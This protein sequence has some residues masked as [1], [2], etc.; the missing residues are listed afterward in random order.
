MMS[1]GASSATPVRE[2]PGTARDGMEARARAGLAA[3]AAAA[4]EAAFTAAADRLEP[5][6]VPWEMHEGHGR[7]TDKSIQP[8]SAP[9]PAMDMSELISRPA[10]HEC[11]LGSDR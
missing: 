5:A 8:A 9:A 3:A 7:A 6:V 11:Y 2:P 4:A 1:P 10:V